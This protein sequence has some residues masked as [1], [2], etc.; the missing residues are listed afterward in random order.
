MLN[1]KHTLHFKVAIEMLKALLLKIDKSRQAFIHY[2]HK[3]PLF[4]RQV[5]SVSLV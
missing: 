2:W 4:F 3:S 5:S 1:N